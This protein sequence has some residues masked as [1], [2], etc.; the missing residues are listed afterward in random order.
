MIVERF[1]TWIESAEEPDRIVAA[2]MLARA[3]LEGALAPEE[4][5]AAE[6]TMTILLDDASPAVREALAHEFAGEAEAPRHI[7]LALASDVPS[8]AAQVLARSPRL[9][10]AELI[11]HAVDG[12]CEQQ[13]AIA[14]RATLSPALTAAFAEHG[15]REVCLALLMNAGASQTLAGLH[16]MAERHGE[17]PDLRRML[18]KRTD[19][20]PA[21][22]LLLIDKLAEGLAQDCTRTVSLSRERIEAL[23]AAS[24]EKAIIA[25]A[26][27][28]EEAELPGIVAALIETGRMT[29]AF[30]LRAVCMGNISLFAGAI[31]HLARQPA[32]RVESVLSGDRSAAFRALYQKAGLPQNAFGVFSGAVALWRQLLSASDA[33]ERARLTYVV[34]RDLVAQYSGEGDP[35]LDGLLVL[36]RRLAAEAARENARAHVVRIA[37]EARERERLML[38]SPQDDEESAEPLEPETISQAEETGDEL[39]LAANAGEGE[40]QDGDHE[41]ADALANLEAGVASL[42]AL[43]LDPQAQLLELYPVIEISVSELSQFAMHFAEEIVEMEGEE[44]GEEIRLFEDDI[45]IIL[46]EE[47]FPSLSALAANDDGAGEAPWVDSPAPLPAPLHVDLGE[48][49]ARR[50]A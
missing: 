34:T 1:L 8:V 26:S 16:R 6:A 12:G 10:D 45:E 30:L 5:D 24:R 43:N 35:G 38:E 33:S 22:R 3:W 4:R 14:C 11:A 37:Q 46:E 25:Y 19:I 40:A 39:P 18:L 15:S 13:L 23:V 21:T 32:R 42:A 7:V 31:G 41:E 48:A 49:S 20:A 2:G 9:L 17:D 50:A 27:R 44:L 29:T 36:L 47:D 28:V